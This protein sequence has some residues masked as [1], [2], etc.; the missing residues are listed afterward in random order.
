MTDEE[1]LKLA[2]EAKDRYDA[3]SPADKLMHDALQRASFVRAFSTPCE[4]GELDFEQCAQCRSV[5]TPAGG[6]EG[7]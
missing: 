6:E 7:R 1:L 4:H 2:R 3:L 5:A